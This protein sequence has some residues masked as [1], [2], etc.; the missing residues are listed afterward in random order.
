MKPIVKLVLLLALIGGLIWGGLAVRGLNAKARVGVG[1]KVKITCSEVFVAG[2][3]FENVIASDFFG[4]DPLLEKAKLKLDRV[5]GAV[6]GQLLGLGRRKAVYREGAGC[7]LLAKGAVSPVNIPAPTQRSSDYTV[8]IKPAVQSAVLALFDDEAL[9]H[10]IVTRGVLVIKDG[11][12]VGEHYAKGFNKD[13]PQQS[14]SMAKS[15]THALVGIASDKGLMALADTGL[16]AQWGEGDARAKISLDNLLQMTSGLGFTEDYADPASDADQMLFN[17]NDTGGFAA[18][19]AL[20]HAPGTHWSYSSGTSNLISKLLRNRING[21][22]GDYHS[23]PMQELFNPIG[24]QSA[25]METDP[26]GTFISSSYMYATPRD[27]A[28]F[29]ELYLNDGMADDRRIL[30][31]GWVAHARRPAMGTQSYYGAQWWLNQDQKR[32]PNMP[33]DTFLMGGNDGQYVIVVPSKNAVIVR[34]GIMRKPA[35]FSTELEPLLT[36]IYDTL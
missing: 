18:S 16:M 15:I 5:G 32:L 23:F 22:G 33:K 24:M 4:I 19:R 34:L 10:P 29:G 1:Y 12:I 31:E 8:E 20:E 25:V 13:T 2:R 28:R 35:R 27:W 17:A 26:S 36:A 21:A 11:K 6:S 3:D 7:T 9:A 30:P 14:W